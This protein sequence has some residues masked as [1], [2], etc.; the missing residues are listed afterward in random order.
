M[1]S[2][3]DIIL[4]LLLA[5]LCGSLIGI[6]REYRAKEA[7]LRT[8]FLLCVGSA[9]FTVVSIYG[10]GGPE[11]QETARVAAQ[12]VSGIGFLGAGTI[13]IHKRFVIGLTTAAGLWTTAAIG[14]A[15]GCGLRIIA[16]GGAVLTLMGFEF[17][18]HISHRIGHIK[19]QIE[20][21]FITGDSD[22]ARAAA[23]QLAKAGYIMLS[24]SS[25][26]A[27]DGRIRVRITVETPEKQSD[28]ARL[29]T[30]FGNIPDAELED[31]E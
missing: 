26:R 12:I 11:R 4:R 6:E 14:M 23:A 31:L 22:S 9:L 18:R 21:V 15:A 17:L 28:P 19:R 2:E 1:Q 13:V 16:V 27:L 29:Y 10:F 24:Y 8:H 7:G 20:L 30:L 5:A 3:F 25:S